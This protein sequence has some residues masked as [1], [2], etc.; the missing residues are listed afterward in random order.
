VGW[1]QRIVRISAPALPG[2]AQ[3]RAVRQAGD[4]MPPMRAGT[5]VYLDL[6]RFLAA[7]TVFASH[8]GT[9]HFT[10]GF[11]YQLQPYGA[12][13]VDVF[14]VLSG[15]VIGCT[16]DRRERDARSYAVNRTARL[17]SVA[18]PAL[19]LT[20]MLDTAGGALRPEMYTTAALPHFNPDG[21][22]WRY[23]V[24]ALFLNETWYLA[25]TP[26]CDFPYWSLGF[27]GW[28]YLIFGVAL[29]AP[30][31]FRVAAT[32]FAAVLAGP[33]VLA[34]APLWLA[35]FA[36]HR[37]TRAGRPSVR[38]GAVCLAASVAGWVGL[39]ARALPDG[40]LLDL[41]PD[42]LGRPELLE[43]YAVGALFA[44]HLIG[45]C[46]LSHGAGRL[47]RPFTRPIRW[48]AGATFSLYLVHYPVMQFLISVM[49][50]PRDAAVSRCMLAGLTLP[51]VFL[52]AEV[53]ERRK[54]A[55]RRLIQTACSRVWPP[56]AEQAVAVPT[57]SAAPAM[58]PTRTREAKRR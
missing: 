36:C 55:W 23:A 37:L 31:R 46:H 42:A 49:P 17:W 10:G 28:Y 18:L 12:E 1:D 16:T 5:S 58:P 21:T 43:D 41:V 56:R 29:F 44:I 30:S 57:G 48:L 8:Y 22:V 53:T 51:A 15:F 52:F 3:G 47:L 9:R 35:G 50:W 4:L 54:G 6:V 20:L 13:A 25:V 26:G 33:R 19:L 14:F 2:R 39:Q 45:I 32:L 27:E 7:L 40:R 11:L 24:S 34:M 38:F